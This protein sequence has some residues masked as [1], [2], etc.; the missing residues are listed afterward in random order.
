[1]FSEAKTSLFLS[2]VDVTLQYIQMLWTLDVSPVVQ[3]LEGVY[4]H[5]FI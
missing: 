2:F 5:G 4:C 3:L 1:M